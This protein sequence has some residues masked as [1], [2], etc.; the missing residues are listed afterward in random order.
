MIPQI[1][2]EGTSTDIFEVKGPSSGTR[3]AKKSE[4][5]FKEKNKISP[6]SS[7]NGKVNTTSKA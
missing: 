1:K 2:D 5:C 6:S 4:V 3:N 7:P